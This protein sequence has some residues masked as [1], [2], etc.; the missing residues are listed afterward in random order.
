MNTIKY[1]N[2]CCWHDSTFAE[3]ASFIEDNGDIVLRIQHAEN[4]VIRCKNYIGLS[5]IGHWEEGVIESIKV[6]GEGDLMKESLNTIRHLNGKPPYSNLCRQM[7]DNWYQLNIK[8]IDG[9]V[10][11]VVCESVILEHE[12]TKDTC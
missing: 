12:Q 3:N 1:I 9:V 4:Y 6:E 7:H 2:S 10:F 8:M 11:K 5:Y